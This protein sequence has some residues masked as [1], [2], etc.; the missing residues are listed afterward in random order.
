M[1]SLSDAIQTD[2]IEAYKSV[3]TKII[4]SGMTDLVLQILPFWMA[5]SLVLWQSI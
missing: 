5:M 4:T 2:V 1:L 3:S